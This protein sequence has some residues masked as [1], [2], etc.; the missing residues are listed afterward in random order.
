MDQVHFLENQTEFWLAKTA[1]LM[2]IAKT[3]A[4]T[5][6]KLGWFKFCRLA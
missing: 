5:E 1:D 3:P 6:K 4:K 2:I